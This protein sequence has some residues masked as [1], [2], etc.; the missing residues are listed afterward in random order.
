MV[1]RPE[2]QRNVERIILESQVARVPYGRFERA[3][4]SG[5]LHLRRNRI[6]QG[7]VVPLFCQ[8]CGVIAGRPSDVENPRVRRDTS[9]DQFLYPLEL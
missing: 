9:I 6:D 4:P 2:E 8:R 7:N 5:L 3:V 1:E